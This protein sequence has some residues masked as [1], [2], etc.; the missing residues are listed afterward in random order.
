MA[1]HSTISCLKNPMEDF[2]LMDRGACQATIEK[3]AKSWTQIGTRAHNTAGYTASL[4]YILF[5]SMHAT[6]LQ[7]CPT[8]CNPM[9]CNL[10]GS[11]VHRILQA[12][13]LKWV[14]MPSSRG[15]FDQGIESVSLMSPALAAGSLPLAP[16]G[17]PFY[18]QLQT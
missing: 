8:L 5:F 15:S 11:S 13:T 12:R 3:A 9:E 10:P 16:P 4:S 17:K 2:L 18:L 7:S 6:L 1:T 14:A